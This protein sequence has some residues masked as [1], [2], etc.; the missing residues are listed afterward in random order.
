LEVL[1]PL[2]ST[3]IYC[4]AL[5]ELT[6]EALAR[7]LNC[8]SNMFCYRDR[9]LL[10]CEELKAVFTDRSALTES[11]IPDQRL[12]SSSQ[13]VTELGFGVVLNDSIVENFFFGIISLHTPQPQLQRSASSNASTKVSLFS[14]ACEWSILEVDHQHM[15]LGIFA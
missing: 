10:T 6:R 5:L 1:I 14:N 4:E 7:I 9:K 2:E 8:G 13:G 3:H 15:F 11:L 12:N